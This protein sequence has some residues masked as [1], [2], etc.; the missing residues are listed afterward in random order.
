MREG[1][2][3]TQRAE[4]FS[5]TSEYLEPC[6]QLASFGFFKS[7]YFCIWTLG[8]KWQNPTETRKIVKIGI[9]GKGPG[10]ELKG[11]LWKPGRLLELMDWHEHWRPSLSIVP[12]TTDEVA[13]YRSFLSHPWTSFLCW[14]IL[15]LPKKKAKEYFFQLFLAPSALEA[16]PFGNTYMRAWI[17]P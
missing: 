2:S 17:V 1:A 3:H 8:C 15:H 10:V 14:G 11:E 16:S 5:R 12:I 6:L 7:G 4:N 9:H 13:I